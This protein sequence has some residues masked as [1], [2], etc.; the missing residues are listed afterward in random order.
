MNVSE[1][2]LELAVR[3]EKTGANGALGDSENGGDFGVGHPL[4]VEHGDDGSV[5][6]GKFVQGGVEALSEV[7]SAGFFVGAGAS[8]DPVEDGLFG[9][10][11]R[12]VE[13]DHRPE[14]PFFEEVEGH[15]VSD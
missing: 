11:I 13:A 15:V 8:A 12:F 5:F 7:G 1:Q 6:C 9:V 14:F 4:D 10:G 3:V 2:P